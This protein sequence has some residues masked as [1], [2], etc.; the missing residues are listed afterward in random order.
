MDNKCTVQV[1]LR[2]VSMRGNHH[3]LGAFLARNAQEAHIIVVL[4]AHANNLDPN[5]HRPFLFS[6][7]DPNFESWY[8]PGLEFRQFGSSPK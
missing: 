5:L 2:V 7:Y 3:G 8:D 6:V 1:N 4:R